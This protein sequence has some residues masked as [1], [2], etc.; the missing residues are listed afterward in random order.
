MLRRTNDRLLGV[1]ETAQ[2]A[3]SRDEAPLGDVLAFGS[4]FVG[5]GFVGGG[6]LGVSSCPGGLALGGM[7]VLL[8]GFDIL[9]GVVSFGSLD[10]NVLLKAERNG[11]RSNRVR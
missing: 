9:L 2:C 3:A 4:S 5:G 1:E 11:L 10:I 6:F 8:H 7:M